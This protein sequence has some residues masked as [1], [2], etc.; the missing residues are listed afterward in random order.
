V[1]IL[2]AKAQRVQVQGVIMRH[3]NRI[4]TPTDLNNGLHD[5]TQQIRG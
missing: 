3:R 5:K 4:C 2:W 1:S